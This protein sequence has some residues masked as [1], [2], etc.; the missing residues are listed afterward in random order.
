MPP[1][2]WPETGL[3]IDRDVPIPMRNGE[4]LRATIHR[5]A[6]DHPVP[7]LLLRLPYNKE[8]AQSYV[9][10]SPAWYARLGYAVVVQDTR[11]CFASEGEF[12]PLRHDDTDGFDTVEWCAA[13]PF[14]NGKVGT[15]GFSYSGINQLLAASERPPHLTAITPGFA[16]SELYDG[17]MYV[18]G[19]FALSAQAHWA[20]VLGPGAAER[21]ADSAALARVRDAHLSVGKWH[22]TLALQDLPLLSDDLFPFFADYLNH[23]SRDGFWS[24]WD[25]EARYFRIE[26]PALHIGGWY[27]TFVPDT[28]QNY[29]RLAQ[30]GRAEQRLLIGPWYHFPWTATVGDID[31]G[32]EALNSVNEYALAWFDAHLKDDRRRLDSLPPVRIFLLGESRWLDLDAW[33][34]PNEPR[35]FYLHSTGSAYLLT[36]EGALDSTPP[37]D[38]P[39]DFFIYDPHDPVPS[40]GGRSGYDPQTT[41][42]GPVDQRLVEQRNDVL[43]FTSQPLSEPLRLIG[44]VHARIWA[45]TTAVDTDFTVKLCDVHP[46]GRS[47]NL[48]EGI[49]RG[50]YRESRESEQ[51]LEPHRVYEFPIDLG[52]TAATIAAGHRLRVQVS[53][54]NYPT[55]DRNSN[56]GG[57]IARDGAMQLVPATQAVFHDARYP[58]HLVLPVAAP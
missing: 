14:C 32:E 43:L 42:M 29:E 49:L 33:P 13:Q 35:P 45:A 39:P 44:H 58:S 21:H 56:S 40:L 28:I 6:V 26:T 36:G 30:M 20:V 25:L 19:A 34:P 23:P 3:I 37:A 2:T 31:Y 17:W 15:Y 46:D 10:G 4:I 12:Y 8:I 24:D 18:G 16:P 55:F 51:L 38:E 1:P 54:S 5:P 57:V 41:P 9:Y 48:C 22:P 11:G 27:D 47:I 53:S 52:V 50:R 7:A